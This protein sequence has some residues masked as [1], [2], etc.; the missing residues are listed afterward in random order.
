MMVAA[1]Q[2]EVRQARLPAVAPVL[3]VMGVDE[4]RVVTAGKRTAS[5]P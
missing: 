2:H 3:D 1:Q 5:I 4:M